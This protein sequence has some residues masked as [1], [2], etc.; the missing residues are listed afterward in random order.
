M[1]EKKYIFTVA[2][3]IKRLERLPQDLK[4]NSYIFQ[5]DDG[6]YRHT[7]ESGTTESIECEESDNPH[8]NEFFEG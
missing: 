7:F 6:E 2:D 1:I 8:E 5:T 4:V 3:F